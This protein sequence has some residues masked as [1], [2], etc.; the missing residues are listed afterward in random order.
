MAGGGAMII[1]QDPCSI[2]NIMIIMGAMR[3][4]YERRATVIHVVIILTTCLQCLSLE[5]WKITP[6]RTQ[7]NYKK[8]DAVSGGTTSAVTMRS[9][10]G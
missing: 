7:K 3:S 10:L 8:M 1:I 4:S 5:S 6:V 2:I 9:R